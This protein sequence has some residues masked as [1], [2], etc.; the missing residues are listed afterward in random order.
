MGSL[1]SKAL[2]TE[3]QRI[4]R[5]RLGASAA[6]LFHIKRGFI[7]Y[8]LGVVALIVLGSGAIPELHKK[9]YANNI[10]ENAMLPGQANMY[11]AQG[12]SRRFD[13]PEGGKE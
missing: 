4:Q 1:I 7:L 11:F 5:A 8:V 12:D 3:A 9:G 13:L 10:D 6:I 2:S